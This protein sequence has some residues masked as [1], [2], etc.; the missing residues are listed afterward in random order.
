M[1]EASTINAELARQIGEIIITM[2]HQDIV[3]QMIERIEQSQTEKGRVFAE[4]A[5]GLTIKEHQID[6][7][8]QAIATILSEFLAREQSYA[9]SYEARGGALAADAGPKIEL[10]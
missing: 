7:A 5:A 4:M 9:R 2:Q 10:F 3:R 8:G 6:F 1:A